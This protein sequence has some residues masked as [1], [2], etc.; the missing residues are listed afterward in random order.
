MSIVAYANIPQHPLKV[1]GISMDNEQETW[2]PIHYDLDSNN[3]K[4]LPNNFLVFRVQ[5]QDVKFREEISNCAFEHT[6]LCPYCHAH[7][8]EYFYKYMIHAKSFYSDASGGKYELEFTIAPKVYTLPHN[9]NWY[10]NNAN[11]NESINRVWLV[12]HLMDEIRKDNGNH[13]FDFKD[14]YEGILIFHSAAGE[15]SDLDRIRTQTLMSAFMPI[16]RF[17]SILAP[18]DKDYRGIP[19]PNNTY[20]TKVGL[21]AAHQFHDYF[22]ER[23]Q[24]YPNNDYRFDIL[25]VLTNH[26]GRLLGFPTLFGNMSETYGR[27]AG[28][29]NFCVM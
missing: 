27:H 18:D 8:Y 4:I 16:E 1:S 11:N 2:R 15:E 13:G 29:G 23:V 21:L 25:G 6:G 3:Q 7:D 20:I 17:N 5:F 12:Q 26:I 19:T 14:H 24:Q 28:V 22:Y 10:G 9:L